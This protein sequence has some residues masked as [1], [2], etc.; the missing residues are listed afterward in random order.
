MEE[1]HFEQPLLKC[2][3]R[4]TPNYYTPAVGWTSHS[5]HHLAESY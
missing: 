3:H 2:L 4:K 5:V 1:F